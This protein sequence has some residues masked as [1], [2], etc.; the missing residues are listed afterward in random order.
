MNEALVCIK[1]KK[2]IR[3]LDHKIFP[4]FHTIK[5]SFSLLGNNL[6]V[7]LRIFRRLSFSLK[8]KNVK[9]AVT[10]W[11]FEKSCFCGL[12]GLQM[13]SR[14]HLYLTT[15]IL[16][17]MILQEGLLYF[18]FTYHNGFQMQT[19]RICVPNCVTITQIYQL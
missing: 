19:F 3:I 9:Y 4:I 10:K 5:F 13:K 11:N 15:N 6:F 17:L 18:N 14:I 2:I 7:I 1:F 8:K 12:T 16:R